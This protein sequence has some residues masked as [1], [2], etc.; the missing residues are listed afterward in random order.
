M[1]RRTV[2]NRYQLEAGISWQI[3]AT[4]RGR[5]NGLVV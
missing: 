4:F 3:L 1:I 2:I 5:E